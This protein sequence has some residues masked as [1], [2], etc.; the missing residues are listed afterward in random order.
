MEENSLYWIAL[1]TQPRHEKVVAHPSADGQQ[2]GIESY[3]PL[4]R[5]LHQ[6]SDRRPLANG[7]VDVPM[8]PSYV[9]ANV[10]NQSYHKIYDAQGIVRVITFNGRIAR[11]RE[12]EIELL[13]RATKSEEP[14]S[15][16]KEIYHKNDEVEIIGGLFTG[17]NG[18]IIRA[19]KKL[20]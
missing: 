12:S 16:S 18:T 5:E 3:V 10:H 14:V 8:I 9:F 4:H 2:C 11:I 13:R 6:W 17:C 20:S 7:W 19:D 1:Y 15:V